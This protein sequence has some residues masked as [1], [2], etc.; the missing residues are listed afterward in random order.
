ML[1]ATFKVSAYLLNQ[2][3]CSDTS[4]ACARDTS[5]NGQVSCGGWHTSH[6]RFCFK[7]K[8]TWKREAGFDP[9]TPAKLRSQCKFTVQDWIPAFSAGSV[10]DL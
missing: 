4:C 6:R 8:S 9:P 2:I 7:D 3:V 10:F 5:E 1:M